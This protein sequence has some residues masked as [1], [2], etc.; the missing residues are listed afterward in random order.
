LKLWDVDDL[1]FAYSD[2]FVLM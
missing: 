1:G 2:V